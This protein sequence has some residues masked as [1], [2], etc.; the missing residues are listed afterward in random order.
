MTRKLLLAAVST[1]FAALLCELILRL[2]A[3]NIYTP[4]VY[5]GEVEAVPDATFDPLLG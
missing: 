5:P 4:P 2:F 1:V 3:G